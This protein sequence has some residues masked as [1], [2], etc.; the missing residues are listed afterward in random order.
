M[1]HLFKYSHQQEK[2]LERMTEEIRF[3]KGLGTGIGRTFKYLDRGRQEEVLRKADENSHFGKGFTSAIA[4]SFRYLSKDSQ[5]EI[6]K[7][8]LKGTDLTDC[9][10]YSRRDGIY[11]T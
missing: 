11:A 5:S 10:Y 6:F 2:M 4:F 7:K 9:R 8:I 1:G 3:S